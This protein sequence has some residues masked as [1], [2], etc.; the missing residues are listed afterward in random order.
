MALSMQ[1]RGF[2]PTQ[3]AW[4]MALMP[5]SRILAPPL[6]GALSDKWLGT[7]RLLRVNTLLAAVGM[8]CLSQSHS[9]LFT[10]AA[11]ALWAFFGSSLIPLSEAG[12][13]QLLGT[14]AANF[15]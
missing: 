11:Y 12:T 1:A 14:K 6:W 10:L 15:G 13:Y 7:S 3:Y 2:R 9:F 4:L 5:L 8:L